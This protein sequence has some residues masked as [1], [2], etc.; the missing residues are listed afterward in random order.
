LIDTAS[1]RAFATSATDWRFLSPK[2]ATKLQSIHSEG[3]RVVVV[4][5]QAGIARAPE[6]EGMIK[7]KIAR[8]A[9]S[10]DI[11]ITFLVAAAKDEYRKPHTAMIDYLTAQLNSDYKVDWS[12]SFYVGDAAGRDVCLAQCSLSLRPVV[13]F[14]LK[15]DKWKGRKKDHS[16]ADRKTA[17]NLGVKYSLYSFCLVSLGLFH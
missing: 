16:C 11:P 15:A 4:T 8:V 6:T 2:V 12:N 1:G 13:Y 14:L 10:L 3:Y 7:E 5:N 17:A 9:T